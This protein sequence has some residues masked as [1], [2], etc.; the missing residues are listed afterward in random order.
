VSNTKFLWNFFRTFAVS[1]LV[2]PS[3]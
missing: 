1:K 2:I 3:V